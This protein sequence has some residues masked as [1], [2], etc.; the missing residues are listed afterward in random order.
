[1]IRVTESRLRMLRN[2]R[3]SEAV[4]GRRRSE[5]GAASGGGGRRGR[6]RRP[7]GRMDHWKG[8]RLAA[9]MVCMRERERAHGAV[10]LLLGS[11]QAIPEECQLLFLSMKASKF[12]YISIWCSFSNTYSALA[13]SKTPTQGASLFRRLYLV[14]NIV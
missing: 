11:R 13:L 3:A 12:Q 2:R 7:S 8:C 1:M 4:S 10:W 6:G 5:D 9:A 14:E